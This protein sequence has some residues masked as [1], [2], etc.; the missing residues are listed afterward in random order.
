MADNL[1]DRGITKAEDRAPAT[2]GAADAN[3]MHVPRVIPGGNVTARLLSAAASTNGTSVKAAPGA[4][5]SVLGYCAAA[6]AVYLKLYDKAS[7]PTVGTDTPVETIRLSPAT[8]FDL[9]VNRNFATGI[10]YAITGA[11]ADADTTALSAG[12]VLCLNIRYL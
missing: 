6:S 8:S 11:A 4:V 3:G 10:A 5:F 7:A 1:V 9:S 12:D 2:L